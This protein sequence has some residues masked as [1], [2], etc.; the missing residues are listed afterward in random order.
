MMLRVG[1]DG[2]VSKVNEEDIVYIERKE[3]EELTNEYNALV[4]ENEQL[5]HDAT[6]LI[7]SNQEY[8]K[9]NEQLREA[10]K[11]S[12]VNEI[13]ENCKYGHYWMSGS[14]GF[15]L[16]GEFECTKKHFGNDHWKC[17][18]LTECDDFELDLKGDDG[19]DD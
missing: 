6:V 7:Y 3:L 17:D 1:D 13:C 12:Y 8:R 14:Y 11:N 9:E 18:G 16:E 5:K 15:G 19:D 4:D 10:L 2:V